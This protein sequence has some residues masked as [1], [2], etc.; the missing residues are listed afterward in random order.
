MPRISRPPLMRST[1][2]ASFSSREGWRNVLLVTRTPSLIRDVATASAARRV[3]ASMHG[4]SGGPS[5][6]TKWSTSQAW[7]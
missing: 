5:V 6:L 1:V 3:Q 2:A 7:S 4:S